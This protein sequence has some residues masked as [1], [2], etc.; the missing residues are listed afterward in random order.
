[1]L[2]LL[3]I[4]FY[5][6]NFGVELV[7]TWSDGV[8]TTAAVDV[9]V[10]DGWVYLI[11]VPQP[12][13]AL[14]DSIWVL[15]ARDFQNIRL[16][17]TFATEVR[18]YDLLT[19]QDYLYTLGGIVETFD[20]SDPA[21]PRRVSRLNLD[22]S[23]A[24]ADKGLGFR[25]FLVYLN[26]IP[27]II[28]GRFLIS[29]ERPDSPQVLSAYRPSWSSPIT[30][31][32]PKYLYA[33]VSGN[34]DT[35]VI[36]DLSD[37][38]NPTPIDTFTTSPYSWSGTLWFNQD[39]TPYLVIGTWAIARLYVYSLENP[40]EPVLVNTIPA[41]PMMVTS[42][43]PRVYCSEFAL[44]VLENLAEGDTV[45]GF[46]DHKGAADEI[47]WHD[48]LIYIASSPAG[49]Y[50]SYDLYIF[51][52]LGDTFRTDTPDLD[53]LPELPPLQFWFSRGKLFFKSP[54]ALELNLRVYDSRG[55][56]VLEESLSVPRGRSSKALE[57][58]SKGIYF[59]LVEDK[60]KETRRVVKFP[61]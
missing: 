21:N 56:L 17:N 4:P 7:A 5:P 32:P 50:P 53:T 54:E 35:V 24:I 48:N 52:Y 15:D 26:G 9:E 3:A 38:E 58:P 8:D 29:L 2:T 14:G 60:A 11:R 33:W 40:E 16:V 61:W 30:F 51:H 34:R 43:G 12:H 18:V 37:P 36:Y 45:V 13:M 31:L 57:L 1:M 41:S 20:I 44:Y 27:V 22:S 46:Y 25:G 6:Q 19:F 49:E 42:H 39:S 28:F 23:A 55:A 47:L 10:K 59:A